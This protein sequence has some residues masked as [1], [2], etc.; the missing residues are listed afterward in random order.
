MILGVLSLSAFTMLHVIISLVA[1]ASGAV[2][3][4]GM[5]GSHRLPGCPAGPRCFS[6]PPSSPASPASCSPS[7]A[8]RRPLGSGLCLSSSW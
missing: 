3:L 1:I 5:L 6:S 4:I 7:T 8:S 2:V